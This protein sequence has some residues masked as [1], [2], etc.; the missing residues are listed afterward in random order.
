[1]KKILILLLFLLNDCDGNF[2]LYFQYYDSNTDEEKVFIEST[3]NKF[4]ELVG[5]L[6][7]HL[8]KIEEDKIA[9]DNNKKKEIQF[10]DRDL[11]NKIRDNYSFVEKNLL[12]EG[13]CLDKDTDIFFPRDAFTQECFYKIDDKCIYTRTEMA[14]FHEIGHAFGL[15]HTNNESDVMY[16]MNKRN[17]S[18]VDFDKF[19][20]DLKSKTNICKGELQ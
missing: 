2:R 18:F 19:V 7:I 14:F 15:K 3:T 1:M 4:N 10:V 11:Y 9:K 5:C 13:M 8:Q 17:R 16:F 12:T 20:N 6:A